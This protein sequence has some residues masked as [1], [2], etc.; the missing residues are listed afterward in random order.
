M[1]VSACAILSPA[2]ACRSSSASSSSF[3][4]C[5]YVSRI[6]HSFL[7]FSGTAILTSLSRCAALP[8]ADDNNRLP[9]CGC[10]QLRNEEALPAVLGRNLMLCD[11]SNLSPVCE[12]PSTREEQ[13]CDSGAAA[14]LLRQVDLRRCDDELRCVELPVLAVSG[15]AVVLGLGG[16][17]PCPTLVAR[18][19]ACSSPD[20]SP[21]CTFLWL[22]MN[23]STSAWMSLFN[24]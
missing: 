4:S 22:C 6:S 9:E 20:R 7:T 14:A 5:W 2:C 10:S 8:R 13:R 1:S 18:F 3:F 15:R 23:R 12:T 17:C 21:A 19:I 11:V 16:K 24:G